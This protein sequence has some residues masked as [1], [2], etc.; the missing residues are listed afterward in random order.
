MNSLSQYLA[1]LLALIGTLVVAGLGFYQWRRQSAN[2]SRG[3]VADSRRTAAEAIWSK[4]E[5]VNLALREANALDRSRFAQLERDVNTIFLK[6]SLYLED[7]TQGLVSEYTRAL[8]KV[9]ALLTA[10]EGADSI[11]WASTSIQISATDSP[12]ARVA[13]DEANHLRTEVKNA[14]LRFTGA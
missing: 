3:A 13:I 5:E 12:E 6:N 2:Q 8:F 4:L 11:E 1:P 10:R 9:S 14:L 7:R